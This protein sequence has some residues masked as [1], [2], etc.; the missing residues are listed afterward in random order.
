MARFGFGKNW[1]KF[2]KRYATEERLADAQ[3]K[4]LDVLLLPNLDGR[5]FLDIG[6]GSGFHSYAAWRAGAKKVI[7]FDYDADSV[8]ATKKLWEMA[9]SPGNWSVMRGDVLDTEFM[10]QFK[11]IDIVYS[12]GVLHHTGNMWKA[13]ENAALPLE[14]RR[15]GIFFIALYSYNSYQSVYKPAPEYWL[16]VKKR[17]NESGVLTKRYLELQYIKRMYFKGKGFK[18]KI[19]DLK[20]FLD[21]RKSIHRRG[22]SLMTDIRDWVGGWPM[23]FVKE[24]ELV[25]FCEQKLHLRLARLLTGGGNTEVVF[26]K[27]HTWLDA[28]LSKRTHRDLPRPFSA[29]GNVG[30]S[31]RL[32]EDFEIADTPAAPRRSTLLLWED[33]K[34]LAYPHGSPVDISHYGHGRFSHHSMRVMNK[35][36]QRLL[37]STSDNSDPNTNGRK[38]TYTIDDPALIAELRNGGTQAP[39]KDPD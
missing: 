14:G 2:V 25:T 8:E 31:S 16:E 35:V 17:Y 24:D 39:S 6:S 20:R 33:G 28:L 11:D 3:N 5:T 15:D 32:Q 23:E 19:R 29:Q 22:M 4:L 13:I 21:A 7:S 9:G 10:R 37:F 1:K 18:E 27:G 36:I 38:Y 12:W 30:W 34:P 26:S